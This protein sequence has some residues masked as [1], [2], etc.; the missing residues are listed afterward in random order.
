MIEGADF[1]HTSGRE[2]LSP[3]DRVGFL[4]SDEM[5]I[6]SAG[7]PPTAADSHLYGSLVGCIRGAQMSGEWAVRMRSEVECQVLAW[8]RGGWEEVRRV[9]AAQKLARR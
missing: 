9:R 6:M 7:R 8:R 1:V 4:A 5:Q 2:N 3:E